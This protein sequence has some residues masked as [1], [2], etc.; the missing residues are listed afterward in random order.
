MSSY[1]SADLRRVVAN[2]S[3]NVCEYCLIHERDTY[4]GCHIDHIISEKHGGLTTSEN[5]CYA[6]AL[7][8]RNK[9]SDIGSFVTG[10]DGLVRFYSPREDVW[11]DHFE[12]QS[13]R[14]E[15][16]TSIGEVTARILRFN[17]AERLMEREALIEVGRYLSLE[18]RELVAA[19]GET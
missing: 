7:C 16:K 1:V 4:L 3:R 15:F 19:Q 11:S 2:R 10:N 13:T 17:T 18:A 5:L 6:C 8:N 12:V 14:I 9:G